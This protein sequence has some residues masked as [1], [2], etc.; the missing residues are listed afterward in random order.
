MG[1]MLTLN[2]GWM[3]DGW[4]DTFYYLYFLPSLLS[5]FLV[6]I[7]I[8]QER[9][10]K[11][12]RKGESTEVFLALPIFQFAPLG[13]VQMHRS[14]TLWPMQLSNAAPSAFGPGVTL[15]VGSFLTILLKAAPPTTTDAHYPLP[16]LYSSPSQL[17]ACTVLYLFVVFAWTKQEFL[18]ILFT[19]RSSVPGT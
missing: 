7:C 17:P 4:M 12:K 14:S 11:L 10:N 15:S 6:W 1:A 18:S 9:E 8:V 19:H 3:M 5:C 16:L 13:K 2:D